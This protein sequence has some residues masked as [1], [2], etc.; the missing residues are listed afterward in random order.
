MK[1]EKY[2]IQFESI[3][4]VMC[5]EIMI[6][7]KE[8]HKQLSFLA[9]QADNTAA[10]EYPVEERTTTEENEKIIIT[11]RLFSVGTGSVYLTSYIC[12]PGYHFK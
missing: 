4:T 11:R 3:D 6:S 8:F 10:D 5:T 9:K 12:K 2:A 7:K 1:T